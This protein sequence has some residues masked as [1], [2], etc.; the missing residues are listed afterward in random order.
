MHSQK[1]TLSDFLCE[2][3]VCMFAIWVGLY[4]IEDNIAFVSR[5]I[6][7]LC[8]VEKIPLLCRTSLSTYSTNKTQLYTL[9]LSTLQLPHTFDWSAVSQVYET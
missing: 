8:G 4:R 1:E 9:R 3:T 7:G 5:I 6:C 2:L